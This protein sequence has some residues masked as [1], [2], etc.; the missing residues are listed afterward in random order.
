MRIEASWRDK[1]P[2]SDMTGGYIGDG[3]PLCVDLPHKMWLRRGAKYRLLGAKHTPELME[4][5]PQFKKDLSMKKFVLGEGSKLKEVLSV[6]NPDKDGNC[7]YAMTVTLESNLACIE[8]ECTADTVRVVNVGEDANPIYY[9]YVSPACVEQAFYDNAKKVIFKD[10]MKDSSCANPLLAYASEAC[11][12]IADVAAYRSPD[13]MYDQERVAFSTAESRCEAMGKKLC[14]FNYINDLDYH[15]KGYH[16][17]KCLSV[18]ITITLSFMCKVT[19]MM[20]DLLV[21]QH[22]IPARSK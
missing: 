15:K 21:L 9:E 11:C 12:S 13:Y 1:F 3:Y 19:Y 2:K 8:E 7:Q 4:D 10:R 5:D 14:D 22:L 18:S 17:S 6:C 20:C 16:W